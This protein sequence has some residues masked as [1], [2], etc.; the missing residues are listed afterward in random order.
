MGWFDLPNDTRAL[1]PYVAHASRVYDKGPH[2]HRVPIVVAEESAV[3]GSKPERTKGPAG[4]S[5]S[6]AYHIRVAGAGAAAPVVR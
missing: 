5:R 4:G 1:P 3:A 6:E 2:P